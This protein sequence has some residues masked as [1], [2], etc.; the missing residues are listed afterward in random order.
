MLSLL[1]VSALQIVV[2]LSDPANLAR[3][4]FGIKKTSLFFGSFFQPRFPAILSSATLASDWPRT[5]DSSQWGGSVGNPRIWQEICGENIWGN[6]CMCTKWDS[7]FQE[8]F[9]SHAFKH[10]FS[11]MLQTPIRRIGISLEQRA[12]KLVQK[13]CV[14]VE[15]VTE[16]N[17]RDLE[18]KSLWNKALGAA[19]SWPA[20]MLNLFR[21]I[22][23]VCLSP[24]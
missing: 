17:E 8:G 12:K 13:C 10:T 11:G 19:L 2:L 9:S 16:T 24:S 23:S 3:E 20:F 15:R 5:E 21:P 7:A 14:P 22:L 6:P 1:F 4:P 18:Q